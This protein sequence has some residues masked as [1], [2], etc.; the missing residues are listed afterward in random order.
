MAEAFVVAFRQPR[1]SRS[2]LQ[3][4][5][6]IRRRAKVFGEPE[7]GVCRDRGLFGKPFNRCAG[8]MQASLAIRLIEA[9]SSRRKLFP[10]HDHHSLNPN[11]NES[12]C[13]TVIRPTISGSDRPMRMLMMIILALMIASVVG[14][15]VVKMFDGGGT[16]SDKPPPV[17]QQPEPK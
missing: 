6:E 9:I 7:S 8:K 14:I 10:E 4:Q 15:L 1:T 2:G 17:I 3:V 12:H 5:P 11:R 13:S 16:K